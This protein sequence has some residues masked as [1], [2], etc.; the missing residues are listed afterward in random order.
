MIEYIK[1]EAVKMENAFRLGEFAN[2]I[3]F[4]MRLDTFEIR[5]VV[6]RR[7]VVRYNEVHPNW[8]LVVKGLCVKMGFVDKNQVTQVTLKEVSIVDYYKQGSCNSAA[9]PYAIDQMQ[10][11]NYDLNQF[12]TSAIFL[13]SIADGRKSAAAMDVDYFNGGQSRNKIN[14]T[15]S[16]TH[17]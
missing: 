14:Q 8:H 11:G 6:P 15:P 16:R 10:A 17:N 3:R 7:E 4:Q 5:L 13:E 12:R 1:N 2:G 9:V